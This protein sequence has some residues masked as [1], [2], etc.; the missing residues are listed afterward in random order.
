M[1]EYRL[2]D[3]TTPVLLS[4]DSAA[5]LRAEAAAILAYLDTHS[6]VDPDRLASHLFRTRIARRYR[7]L[8]MVGTRE[9]LLDALRSV[10]A[11]AAHPAV[12]TSDGAVPAGRVGFV[13]PGQ[14]SQRPGMGKPYYDFS[15]AYRAA[16]DECAAVHEERYGHAR[17]VHY[18]L[19]ADEE[20]GETLWEVQPARM[21][22]LIGLAAMWRAA[23]V[24]PTATIGHSQGELA[25]CVVSGAMT[26]RDA[27][28]VVTHRAQLLERD[29]SDGYAVAV[30]GA[31]REECEELLARNSGWAE[32][33]IINSPRLIGVSGHEAAIAEL[34]ATATAKGLFA[35]RIQM[36][37]PSHTSAMTRLRV[38]F[39]S[40]LEE[41]SSKT[42]TLGEID[43]YGGTLGAAIT[44]EVTHHDYWYW[45][46]RNRVRFDRAIMA[47]SEN[48]DTFVEIAEH[49][50]LQPALRENLSGV[51]SEPARAAREF[52]I[53]G[54]SLRTANGLGEFTRNVAEVAVHDPHYDWQALRTGS[55]QRTRALPLRD[56][57]ATVMNQKRLWAPYQSGMEAPVP[58]AVPPVRLREEWAK[59]S[60]I[61]LAEP[62]TVLF[63][64]HDGRADA[65]ATAMR[66]RAP[67]HGAAISDAET[68]A[69]TMVLLLAPVAADD[70]EGA[71]AELA[72]F[73]RTAEPL[74]AIVPGVTECWLVTTGAE[75][76]TAEDVPSL[77]HSA[78]SAAYRSLGLDHLGIAF[79]HLD[80]PPDAAAQDPAAL[81]DKI[82][83]AIHVLGEPEL[84]L[85]DGKLHAK[86]LVRAEPSGDSTSPDL[87]EVVILGGTGCVGLEF[88]AQFV[89]D[90][91]RRITL[92]NRTGETSALTERLRVIRKLGR[93]E[94]DVVA[95]DITDGA[96][97]ADLARRFAERPVSVVVH[98][99]VQYAWAGFEPAA[100]VEAAAAKVLG[101]AEVL[102]AVPLAADCTVLLCSSFVAT[103][104]GREQAL[105]AATNRMLDSL[106]VR[107][108]AQGR[109][110]VSV[111]WGLWGLPGAEH[112]AVEARIL[113]AGLQ[114]MPAMPAIAAG[115][116]DRT[117]NAVVLSADWER[118]RETVEL[119]GLTTVFASAFPAPEPSAPVATASAPPPSTA[120]EPQA[121]ATD[122]FA[123]IIRR[124]LG[125]VML[126]DGPDHID[127]S[128]PLVALGFDSLQAVDLR[129]RI[130]TTLNRE[131]PVAAILGGASLDDVVLLMSEN[132][133]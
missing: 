114:P 9:E 7:A 62:R 15:P 21:F 122:D 63:A 16:V 47:A 11:D 90:G 104:G 69:D 5:G 96:A 55:A 84:A 111:Q 2:P 60:R 71:V 33:S 102:R 28:L 27:V 13:F 25:A 6:R 127:G 74:T 75:A 91:A 85:R 1:P 103:L 59:L 116:A 14:G 83:E 23:G 10:A 58:V 79:R 61:A 77:G 107:L 120:V 40:A 43:C 82:F 24:R 26:L 89:R 67:R 105:Y 36:S 93:T 123:E 17:P 44:A 37:F 56:F 73:A 92:V 68:P 132:R 121:D 80:L 128:V 49:P 87:R 70:E 12:V 108:R 34:V 113:G 29:L 32:V 30:L 57:P 76:V 98:A 39:Q 106:A 131:L 86:R 4:S 46:L 35:R 31:E 99:A 133:G 65:L 118:L 19:A 45:N 100:V 110:C 101:V 72:A 109:D 115:L 112:A 64:E 124:E 3:G 50:T 130:K 129:A 51:A 95:C 81:A 41:L 22:H 8:V 48:V 20:Y 97:V 78:A 125:Q 42:F 66:A 117:G 18:L 88:C 54:T 126:V 53:V 52:R 119:V 94:I 38:E